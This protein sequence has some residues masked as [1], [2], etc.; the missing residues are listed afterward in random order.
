MALLDVNDL[1]NPPQP[2]WLTV[3]LRLRPAAPPPTGFLPAMGS[4]LKSGAVWTSRQRSRA[5]CSRHRR[6]DWTAKTSGV[7]CCGRKGWEQQAQA[8]AT[9]EL[10]QQG[11][12]G[13]PK[14]FAYHL[15]QA[16]PGT[17]AMIGG[18]A[19]APETA[20]GRIAGAGVAA[21][22]SMFGSNIQNEEQSGPLTQGGAAR[23]A[24]LA[25]PESAAMGFMPSSSG[26][27]R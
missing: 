1:V 19:L 21:F 15:A 16:I 23:A 27:V 18:A 4:A 17:A 3:C 26:E 7:R 25:V 8:A 10:E 20:L 13:S 24:G 12:F 14:S 5:D 2:N 9:P 6:A 11:W 22:P